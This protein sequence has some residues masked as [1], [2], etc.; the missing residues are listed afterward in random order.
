M[1]VSVSSLINLY[2]ILRDQSILISYFLTVQRHRQQHKNIASLPRTLT[3]SR[4]RPRTHTRIRDQCLNMVAILPSPTRYSPTPRNRSAIRK[5]H[6]S[7]TTTTLLL[8][9]RMFFFCVRF[10]HDQIIIASAL[11]VHD[12]HDIHDSLSPVHC[13]CLLSLSHFPSVSVRFVLVSSCIFDEFR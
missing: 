6:F 2:I 7:S 5:T 1:S 8:Y 11:R 10:S 4:S 3:P 13:P 9:L 12:F